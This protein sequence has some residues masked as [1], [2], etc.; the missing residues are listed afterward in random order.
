ME[1]EFTTLGERGQAV[2]PKSIREKMP[3]PK[4]TI[5]SIYL[6]DKD[7]LVM[8]RIDKKKLL[9]DFKNLRVSIKNRLNEAEIVK[10]IKESRKK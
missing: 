4:G 3:A 1:V 7:I 2:I 5:F 8:K 9:D 6:V 10:E